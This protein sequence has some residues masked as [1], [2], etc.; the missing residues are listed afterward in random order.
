MEWEEKAKQY[1]IELNINVSEGTKSSNNKNNN[2][3][4]CNN[5][6]KQLS[7]KRQVYRGV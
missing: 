1:H 5:S 3:N 2:E 6:P 7:S 4:S